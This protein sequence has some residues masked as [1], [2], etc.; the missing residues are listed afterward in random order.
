VGREGGILV[1]LLALSF[2]IGCGAEQ[3]APSG[4]EGPE[5]T[6]FSTGTAHVELTGD[7]EATIDLALVS[8]RESSY[9]DGHVSLSWEDEQGN[10]MSIAA[11]PKNGEADART[12]QAPLLANFV[13]EE[14]SFGSEA[15][16]TCAATFETLSSEAVS[17]TLTC[18]ALRVPEAERFRSVDV[19]ATFSASA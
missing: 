13:V 10:F 6:G 9:E 12:D 16:R 14:Q 18:S 8:D 7:L 11:T 5:S 15:T 3:S 4:R 17:G 19:E 2:V 1:L